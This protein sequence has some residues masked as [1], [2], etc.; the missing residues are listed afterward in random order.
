MA[1]KNV[2]ARALFSFDS[3]LQKGQIQQFVNQTDL[4]N[5]DTVMA[6]QQRRQDLE[7]FLR[8]AVSKTRFYAGLDLSGGLGK[9][10]V[11]DKSVVKEHSE[12]M[13]SSEF[14]TDELFKAETSGSTGIPL[15]VFHSRYKRRLMNAESIYFGEQGGYTFGQKLFMLLNWSTR[16]QRSKLDRL[17]VNFEF[18]DV[19]RFDQQCALELIERLQN[20]R[21]TCSLLA[22]PS[23]LHVVVKAAENVGIEK[24]NTR[25]TSVI[26]QS[27]V[28]YP[29]LRARVERLF[30][31]KPFDRYG[32]EEFG[33][34]AQ[35]T[36]SSPE[37]YVVNRASKYVEIM[38]VDSDEP[39]KVGELGRVVVTDVSGL[40][41]PMIRYDTGDLAI[42]VEQDSAGCASKIREIQ[43]RR[44]DQIYD[45]KDQQIS[46]WVFN[47]TYW[48]YP[49]IQQYQIVQTGSGEY[50][51]K[52]SAPKEFEGDESFRRELEGHLGEGARVRL[53][54]V[55]NIPVLKSGKQKVVVSEY[56]PEFP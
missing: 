29:D 42:L 52:I 20:S 27:E 14:L 41:Q 16:K 15:A 23:G 11:I 8:Y 1:S 50:A 36:L 32:L 51:L 10:P 9:F 45:A 44:L 19:L 48:K 55:A 21:R 53:E 31:V 13:L 3:I 54:R 7:V 2:R 6:V 40:A 28:S 46:P 35:Q 38:S 26:T 37:D 5:L 22:F 33:I 17:L 39:V 24:V 56:A 47:H 25:L 4:L 18:L 12:S 30:G 49:E 43:G 34:V